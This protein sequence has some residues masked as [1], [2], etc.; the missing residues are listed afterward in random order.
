LLTCV[1]GG[2]KAVGQGFSIVGVAAPVRRQNY[3]TLRNEPV[4]S[5]ELARDN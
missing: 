3:R 1:V 5:R 2:K 4:L